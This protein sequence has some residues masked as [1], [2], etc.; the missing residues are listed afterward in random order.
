MRAERFRLIDELLDGALERGVG[1]RAAFLDAACA[2]DGELRAAVESL[3]AA[4]GRAGDFIESPAL[5]V[6]AR[7]AVTSEVGRRV[8][9]YKILSLL[10]AGGMGEVYLAEDAR[11]DRRVALKLLPAEFTRDPERVRRFE[12]EARAASAL[13]HPNIV[14]IHEV[15][16]SDGAHFIAAEFVE[17]RTLRRLMADTVLKTEEALSIA[18]QVAEAL[19][20]A[21]AAGIIH[22]DIKP[23]NIMLR[24][25]GYVKV[26]DFGVAKLTERGSSSSDGAADAAQQTETGAVVGTVAYM[27]PEQALG[28]KLD[29]RTDVFSLG[30]LLYEM[31]A[32]EH[33]FRGMT[34][35]A[36]FDRIL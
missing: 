34:N 36:T 10:G 26:L 18:A 27:S 3:L 25:D 5:E 31:L 1:E 16:Q 4:H 29:Q 32:G 22:R 33:P 11:L 14:T 20:A 8:G 35:A 12:R 2:G 23:E 30:V 6:A 28:R 15:G 24:P 9:P 19:A 13:N 21:H 17:G 7:L